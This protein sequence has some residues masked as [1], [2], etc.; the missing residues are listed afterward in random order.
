MGMYAVSQFYLQ[1]VVKPS[2]SL[3]T[4]LVIGLVCSTP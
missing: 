2:R 4:G 1:D 3:T